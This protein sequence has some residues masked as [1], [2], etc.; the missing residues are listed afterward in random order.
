LEILLAIA[1]AAL[2]SLWIGRRDQARIERISAWFRLFRS[3]VPKDSVPYVRL[4]LQNG[5]IYGGYVA[6]YSEQLDSNEREIV[7][8][9]PL[10]YRP[11]NGE[12]EV[13]DDAWQRVVVP[14][15]E[16][17]SMRVSYVRS[18]KPMPE[19]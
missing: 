8:R 9:P 1:F 3:E 11:V 16:I 18:K 19:S 15:A 6:N 14:G 10:S 2:A 5:E 12:T 13:L 17:A 4:Q 7:L